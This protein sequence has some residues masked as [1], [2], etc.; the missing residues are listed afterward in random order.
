MAIAL[1]LPFPQLVSRKRIFAARRAAHFDERSGA[2]DQGRDARRLVGVLRECR[3]KRQ[4]D[5]NMRIDE[6]GKNKLASGIDNFRIGRNAQISANPRDGLGLHKKVALV[7]RV[8]GNHYSVLNQQ[9]HSLVNVNIGLFTIPFHGFPILRDVGL[10]LGE[11][12]PCDRGPA[13]RQFHH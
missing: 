12:A 1:S 5:V 13:R 4:I 8:G 2:A 10:R 11:L 7:T 9:R 3:H 6:T